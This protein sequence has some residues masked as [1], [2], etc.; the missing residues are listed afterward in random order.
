MH[1]PHEHICFTTACRNHQQDKSSPSNRCPIDSGWKSWGMRS[2][3]R[4]RHIFWPS[5]AEMVH[6]SE[7]PANACRLTT[8]GD[9]DEVR[10]RVK[11]TTLIICTENQL[12]CRKEVTNNPVTMSPN[13]ADFTSHSV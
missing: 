1:E 13:S 5:S 8:S 9:G 11:A 7:Q 10:C 12:G 3:R 4:C 2:S 6:S